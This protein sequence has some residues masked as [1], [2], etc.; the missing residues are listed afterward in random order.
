MKCA[1]FL[2][3]VPHSESPASVGCVPSDSLRAMAGP[4]DEVVAKVN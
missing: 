4:L 1:F 3:V 2:G